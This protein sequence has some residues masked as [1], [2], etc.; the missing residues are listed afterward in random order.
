MGSESLLRAACEK[1][2]SVARDGSEADPA[3]E[4]PESMR[5]FLYVA[6]LPRRAITVAQRALEDDDGFRSR[7]AE[8][9]TAEE[10]GEAGY[11]WLQREQGWEAEFEKFKQDADSQEV[12]QAV[13]ASGAA[14]GRQT[15]TIPPPPGFEP[16]QFSAESDENSN[17]NGSPDSTGGSANDSGDVDSI[18]HEL[19]SLRGLVDRLANERQADQDGGVEND[20]GD[21]VQQSKI[22]AEGAPMKASKERQ[23]STADADHKKLADDLERAV[24][25]R[26]EARRKHSTSLT[27]QLEL[28]K[29]LTKLRKG[30]N[31][32]DAAQAEADSRLVESRRE[33]ARVT[34]NRDEVERQRAATVEQ[35]NALNNEINRLRGDAK[36]SVAVTRQ[37]EA[38][39]AEQSEEK[40]AAQDDLEQAA[41]RAQRLV[42]TNEDLSRRLVESEQEIE[43]HRVELDGFADLARRS[44]TI[45]SESEDLAEQLAAERAN[46]EAAHGELLAERSRIDELAGKT[47]E[48]KSERDGLANQVATLQESLSE[49]LTDLS[50]SRVSR[51]AERVS[52]QEY[53]AERDELQVELA[54]LQEVDSEQ[55]AKVDSLMAEQSAHVALRQRSEELEERVVELDISTSKLETDLARVVSERDK[56]REQKDSQND[57]LETLRSD[58]ARLTQDSSSSAEALEK[59]E[60]SLQEVRVERETLATQLAEVEQRASAADAQ[61][62]RFQE[63]LEEALSNLG[64][65][66]SQIESQG[67]EIASKAA[68]LA[69]ERERADE[70][71]VAAE[72]HEK[73]LEALTNKTDQDHSSASELDAVK[74]QAEQAASELEK[75]NRELEKSEKELVESSREI[76][77]VQ[78]ELR[79]VKAELEEVKASAGETPDAGPD[80]SSGKAEDESILAQVAA[81]QDVTE[82][83]LA[84]DQPSPDGSLEKADGVKSEQTKLDEASPDSL[85]TKVDESSSDDDDSSS[86]S[87][88]QDDA[89]SA[90]DISDGSGVASLIRTAPD[91]DDTDDS[92]SKSI[93]PP[94][95][96]DAETTPPEGKGDNDELD[97]VSNL[98]S[99]EITG[100]TGTDEEESEDPS[101]VTFFGERSGDSEGPGIGRPPSVFTTGELAQAATEDAD[102]DSDVTF[103]PPSDTPISSVSPLT[104]PGDEEDDAS[105]VPS[106]ERRKIEIPSEIASRGG[107]D[108]A[109]FVVE[110]PEIVLLVDGD[111]VAKLGWASRSVEEQR[112]A[113]VSWLADLTASTGASSDVVF[114]GRL[115]DDGTLPISRVVSIRVSTPPTEPAAALEELVDAY[116]PQ[117]PIAVVTDNSALSEAAESRGAVGLSNAQLLDLFTPE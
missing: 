92:N 28:E 21:G 60:G 5:S 14:P 12:K 72:T 80:A 105:L 41:V 95:V 93:R 113:L 75:A 43:R 37:L 35:M 16:G 87:D 107:V 88:D 112:E 7:V 78:E 4:P 77:K 83:L 98:I 39:L 31:T 26:D 51:D 23:S 62:S 34:A 48:F 67:E 11:V 106:T 13:G 84:D 50:E 20:G 8:A 104:S 55:S 96:L 101:N 116:P 22:E 70:Y 71:R 10:V 15:P 25:D 54:R 40:K 46:V 49:A 73:A 38:D 56:A 45:Q 89:S 86:S 42:V 2:F 52:T 47:S 33:L 94:S 19:S 30:Q 97:K 69:S 111:G 81:T 79:Q 99:Q 18:E 32:V 82:T 114:D 90:S 3:V 110:S 17:G 115:N 68:E 108:F 36:A 91:V 74:G 100:F 109:R 76:S 9:A 24:R 1:A 103:Q 65:I 27:H 57:E 58:V 6:R 66:Q 44:Q 117:F 59:A 102:E 53:R 61:A 64:A 63:Q 29:E 85:D